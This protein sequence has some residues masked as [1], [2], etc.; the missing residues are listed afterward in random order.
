MDENLTQLMVDRFY[1]KDTLESESIAGVPDDEFEEIYRIASDVVTLG[2]RVL[3]VGCGTGKMTGLLAEKGHN[4]QG[5]DASSY[6][7]EQARKRNPEITYSVGDAHYQSTYP[8]DFDWIISRQV[9][10]HFFDPERVFKN[11]YNA[12]TIGGS[13]VITDGL[14]RQEEWEADDLVEK[15]P[16][17]CIS[18]TSPVEDALRKC[19]F[20]IR[21]TGFLNEVEKVYANRK[22]LIVAQR[23]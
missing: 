2:E 14:W 21:H 20:T 1:T 22:Y 10:C 12:L 15:S 7:I 6:V 9:V 3:E 4:A 16:L 11:W 8:G 13:V 5:V 23:S 18:D 19:G 17:S